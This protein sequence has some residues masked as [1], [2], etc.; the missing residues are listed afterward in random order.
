VIPVLCQEC[1]KRPA[2]VHLTQIINGQK[3][4]LHLCEQCARARGELGIIGEPFTIPTL[5]SSIITDGGHT[6]PGAGQAAGLRCER[7]GL[8]YAEFARTGMLGCRHCYQA[9]ENQLDSV[10]RRLHG[11]TVHAGKVP[12][13]TG[14]EARV[15]R[16]INRLQE[17]LAQVVI[18]EEY[19]KAAQIRDRIRELE[20]KLR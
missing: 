20:K 4:E 6:F 15:K 2:T 17:E 11:T 8:T 9:F 18:R 14:E 12:S 7:C 16:E 3:R 1:G 10:L 5:L 13:R 19:E